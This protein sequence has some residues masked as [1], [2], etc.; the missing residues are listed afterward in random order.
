MDASAVAALDG[1]SPSVA[2]ARR[3]GVPALRRDRSLPTG[4]SSSGGG[5]GGGAGSASTEASPAEQQAANAAVV[6]SVSIPAASASSPKKDAASPP[7]LA[8]GS[9]VLGPLNH[10]P[11][12][13]RF[14]STGSR[15]SLG[16][17]STSSSG[18]GGTGSF[19][20]S[21]GGGINLSTN[22]ASGGG[23]KA[24]GNSID[25]GSTSV[26]SLSPRSH[27]SSS[28]SMRR[29]SAGSLDDM[30]SPPASSPTAGSGATLASPVGSGG[31]EH[32]LRGSGN[33]ESTFRM[34]S[35]QNELLL[36]KKEQK[37][38]KVLRT[39]SQLSLTLDE[40]PLRRSLSAQEAGSS[41]LSS[42]NTPDSSPTADATHRAR[43]ARDR[44]R[45]ARSA[46][47]ARYRAERERENGEESKEQP[48]EPPCTTVVTVD[49]EALTPVLPPESPDLLPVPELSRSITL[50]TRPAIR[51]I[52]LAHS[53]TLRSPASADGSNPPMDLPP[54][55]AALV[56][57]QNAFEAEH[58]ARQQAQAAEMNRIA[59]AIADSQ[60]QQQQQQLQVP[61]SSA[62]SGSASGSSVDSSLSPPVFFS[63]IDDADDDQKC[64]R[65]SALVPSPAG[66]GA[67]SP[68]SSPLAVTPANAT[69]R[70]KNPARNS[71]DA[72][73]ILKLGAAAIG[74]ASTSRAGSTPRAGSGPSSSGNTLEPLDR[75]GSRSYN[76]RPSRLANLPPLPDTPLNSTPSS[77]QNSRPNS[78]PSSRQPSPGRS[79][80]G[81]QQQQQIQPASSAEPAGAGQLDPSSQTRPSY[82]K[83]LTYSVSGSSANG[84]SAPNSPAYLEPYGSRSY[85]NALAT[86]V[87]QGGRSNSRSRSPSPGSAAEVKRHV[88]FAAELTEEQRYEPRSRSVTPQPMYGDKRNSKKNS[89]GN[90]KSS[91]SA[92]STAIVPRKPK[93][94]LRPP[95]NHH[96]S[97]HMRHVVQQLISPPPAGS[98]GASGAN[99]P[100]PIATFS[101]H[102]P[103]V[104]PLSLLKFQVAL[105]HD[106]NNLHAYCINVT[107]TGSVLIKYNSSG[108]PMNR[109][110]Y[111]QETADEIKL[112]WASPKTPGRNKTWHEANPNGLGFKPPEITE[113][114]ALANAAAAATGSKHDS[115]GTKSPGGSNSADSLHSDP[116]T[117]SRG[118]SSSSLLPSFSIGR[119]KFN[120]DRSRSLLEIQ[121]IHYGPSSRVQQQR[122]SNACVAACEWNCLAHSFAVRSPLFSSLA[123]R[124][125]LL[126]EFLSFP[127]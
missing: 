68:P 26:N 65:E 88:V 83:S 64:D 52:G 47:A 67:P 41:L 9:P 45:A 8:D 39:S 43:E 76:S 30:L 46:A 6:A 44:E 85:A 15:S 108:K 19:R 104:S 4:S 42:I 29:T 103:F 114:A 2:H 34:I 77:R 25:L 120:Q 22:S 5:G 87:A 55:E 80:Q 101:S 75:R 82:I 53:H 81:Q 11:A 122:S 106:Q 28:A 107:R 97:Q 91:A 13:I 23:D 17:P 112:C 54:S 123:G 3:L 21:A 35:A 116:P 24:G 50:P 102:A 32:G 79:S 61:P 33:F 31:W 59:Q 78:R 95:S 127:R 57:M 126:R 109:W 121:G 119:W 40:E 89:S 48:E 10:R 98:A 71:A 27:R 72:V 96:I 74:A 100:G 56:G 51:T 62:G 58:A 110:F 84:F 20:S 113:A 118:G 73:E 70:T 94:I 115:G 66:P 105:F 63:P 1:T 69:A 99:A 12:L 86:A 18:G 37:R 7:L 14:S 117:R 90:G 60:Q 125:I 49:E 38:Q 92:A 16:L 36:Q 111:V 124:S 93:S